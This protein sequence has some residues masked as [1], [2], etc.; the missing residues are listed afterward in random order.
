MG[1]DPASVIYHAIDHGTK[2]GADLV[3]ADSAGRLH[4][5][6]ELMDEIKKVKRS[7]GKACPGSPH[8]IWLVVDATTGQNALH[9]AREFHQAL[10]LTGVI[11]TKLDGTAKGG[12]VV[13]MTEALHLPICFVG[14]GESP[15]DLRPFVPEA[16]VAAMFS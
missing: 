4:T 3:L 10:T 11:L 2:T 15:S 16:F 6:T 1:T 5:K 9:Q 12:I 7:A 14:V 13:A 8:E